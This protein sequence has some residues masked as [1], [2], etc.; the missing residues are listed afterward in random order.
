MQPQTIGAMALW[1]TGNQ[2][3]CFLIICKRAKLV[4]EAEH[5]F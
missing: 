3:S 1:P 5:L 2:Q 4:A